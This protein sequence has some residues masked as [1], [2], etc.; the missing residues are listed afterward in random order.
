M[1]EQEKGKAKES[2]GKHLRIQAPFLDLAPISSTLCSIFLI[3]RTPYLHRFAR[4]PLCFGS[5]LFV[6]H[7]PRGMMKPWSLRFTSVVGLLLILN[8]LHG[9]GFPA[10]PP[11]MR[12]FPNSLDK[13]VSF[14]EDLPQEARALVMDL[15]E[16]TMK[17]LTSAS[18]YGGMVCLTNI[19]GPKL[20]LQLHNEAKALRGSLK[21]SEYWN[22]W[23]EGRADSYCLIDKGTCELMGYAA[24]TFAIELL[25]AIC[26][27][28][29]DFDGGKIGVRPTAKLQLSCFAAGSAGYEAHSDGSE[30]EELG[31]MPED[32]RRMIS[33][34][35][36]TAI[37][38]LNEQWEDSNGGALRAFGEDE[39]SY[40]EAFPHGGSLVLFRSRD[41]VHQVLP[42]SRDRYAL[43]MWY[44][45]EDVSM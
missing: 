15:D 3:S 6:F 35:R 17:Y 26:Q 27:R 4:F 29:A 40:V 11:V 1:A 24:M 2:N 42:T 33:A 12:P 32:Q 30:A 25:E 34:R 18:E 43:T 44:V 28:L 19:V 9:L 37:L 22:R 10:V 21:P 8:S 23:Q 16:E 39:S 7:P 31:A 14:G 36:I 5:D 20:M 41:L 38:Y 45:S 13:A